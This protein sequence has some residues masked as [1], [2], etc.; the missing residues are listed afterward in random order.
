LVTTGTR[1]TE[2]FLF[3]LRIPLI[4]SGRS[5]RELHFYRLADKALEH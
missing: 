2:L 1:R 5:F 4:D 3:M